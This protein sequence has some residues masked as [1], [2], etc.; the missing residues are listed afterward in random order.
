[1]VSPIDSKE[2]GDGTEIYQKDFDQEIDQSAI[3]ENINFTCVGKAYP[4][5]V[6]TPICDII[7]KRAPY[8][9]VVQIIPAKW[10]YEKFLLSKNLTEKQMIGVDNVPSKQLG[11]IKREFMTQ[12]I[13]NRTYRYHFLPKLENIVDNS[14]IDFQMVQTIYPEDLE[15]HRKIA[16]LRSPWRESVPSRYAAYCLR[17]GTPRYSK[18]FLNTIFDSI[19]SLT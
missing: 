9:K 3:Y 2:I 6:L 10:V 5:I 18:E 11:A 17:I 7:T 1:M 19:S 15:K 12:Y 14:F 8:L 13:G 4:G 16:A